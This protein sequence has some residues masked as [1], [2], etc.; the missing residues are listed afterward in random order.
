MIDSQFHQ[1]FHD[2][3]VVFKDHSTTTDF[4]PHDI[5]QILALIA[6]FM[7]P[8][9]GP[10]GA[11]RNQVGPMLAPWTSLSGCLTILLLTCRLSTKSSKRG[12]SMA[13]WKTAVSPLLMHWQYCSLSLSHQYAVV[14][15]CFTVITSSLPLDLCDLFFYIIKSCFIGTRQS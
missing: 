5:L 2:W 6:R 11:D 1:W 14:M 9:W 4:I 12:T 10:S 7:G 3:Y 13:Q 8:M 15:L